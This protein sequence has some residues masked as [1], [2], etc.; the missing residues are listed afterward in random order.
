MVCD[1]LYERGECGG[2]SAP[3]EL[4]DVVE[5][6]RVGSER[7]Q[8]LEKQRLVAALAEHLRREGFDCAMRDL[9]QDGPSSGA[10]FAIVIA[11]CS[12]AR[13][14]SELRRSTAT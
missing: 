14:V 13:R 12:C 10:L 3:R 7:G 4:I 2:R 6:R 1:A 11:V 8:L 5:E 9:G